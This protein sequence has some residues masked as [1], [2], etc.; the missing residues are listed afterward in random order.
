MSDRQAVS[1]SKVV[2]YFRECINRG[3]LDHEDKLPSER[4]ISELIGSSR[5]TTREGLKQLEAEGI[6]YRSNR[7]GWFVT[8]RRIDYDPSR[9]T[10]F[11]EYVLEQGFDP[12]SIQLNKYRVIANA[13]MASLMG[14][15]EGEQLVCLERIR[16]VN[17][18][19]V[20]L[21]RIWLLERQLP[22]IFEMDL[23]RSVSAVTF[24]HFGKEYGDVALD[25]RAGC[26]SAD[27]AEQLQA[28]TGYSCIKISRRTSD[29]HGQFFEYDEELW[30]H[31]ALALKVNLQN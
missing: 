6:I 28:P 15:D 13:A 4:E 12:F 1:S 26:L 24:G 31:D 14:I 10:F 5:V 16:G 9:T 20:Y 21:E 25:I 18:R 22:G 30:R 29:Q 23:E 2:E 19:P 7:R 17:K 11:F 3:D 8:P 27:Q